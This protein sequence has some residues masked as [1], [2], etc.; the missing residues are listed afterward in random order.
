MGICCGCTSAGVLMDEFF[1]VPASADTVRKYL[2]A[3][4]SW[5]KIIP[6]AKQAGDKASV[7][8]GKNLDF[9]IAYPGYEVFI[10][11]VKEEE[12]A[13]AISYRVSLGS[14]SSPDGTFEV[15]WTFHAEPPPGQGTLKQYGSSGQQQ[16]APQEG[17]GGDA[18]GGSGGTFV[19]RCITNFQA[20]RNLCLPWT[21]GLRDACQKENGNIVEAHE[22]KTS[23]VAAT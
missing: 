15:R 11:D 1:Y 23:V 21:L 19:R 14:D 12:K 16:Q 5:V 8:K 3:P 22:T 9:V 2:L 13:G 18:G 17:G 10:Q 6:G 20:H 4:E 7:R